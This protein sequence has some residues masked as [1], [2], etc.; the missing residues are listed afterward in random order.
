MPNGPQPQDLGFV[1]IQCLSFGG[2]RH[3]TLDN[4]VGTL[5]RGDPPSVSFPSAAWLHVGG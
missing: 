3:L 2:M 5:I 1:L 4:V